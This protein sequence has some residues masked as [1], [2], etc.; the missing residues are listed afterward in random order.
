MHS[1]F[2]ITQENKKGERDKEILKNIQVKDEIKYFQRKGHML[3]LSLF[4]VYLSHSN[5]KD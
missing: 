1:V 3:S 2:C 5:A 4:F